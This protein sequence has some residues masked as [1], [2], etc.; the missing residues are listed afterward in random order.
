MPG[1]CG[2]GTE[3]ST[4]VGANSAAPRIHAVGEG[5]PPRECAQVRGHGP[6]R[7]QG[8]ARHRAR[9]RI[10][11]AALL[12]DYWDV[13]AALQS[14]SGPVA[15]RRSSPRSHAPCMPRWPNL[16]IAGAPKCG[17]TALARYLGSHPDVF[18]STPKEPFH[19][20]SDLQPN[21]RY[22]DEAAYVELFA[23]TA[24]RVRGEAST[25][26][27]YSQVAAP[28]IRSFNP[29]A[30]IVVMLR[31]PVEMLP[32]LHAQF[33]WSGLE[34][35]PDFGRAWRMQAERAPHGFLQYRG[36]A[37]FGEQLDRLYSVF[38]REQVLVVFMQDFRADT[39]SVYRH[40]LD[41]LGLDDDGRETFEVFNARKAPRSRLLHRLVR[42][43]PAPL[44]WMA[45]GVKKAL[46]LRRLGILARVER[47]NI[48]RVETKPLPTELRSEIQSA[49]APDIRRLEELT[50]RDLAAWLP[51]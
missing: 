13:T 46:G 38:P 16:F 51:S 7:Q 4:V 10:A 32:S 39:L 8:R 22:H 48:R 23:Q 40:T 20:S 19:F 50:G 36:V 33:R 26:Y 12:L 9:R 15:I 21:A 43:T 5:L 37:S 45:R 25:W 17:T 41:F 1:R 31:N 11:G 14:T 28:R 6:Q 30:R 24:A 27:L 34:H 18:M 3:G 47:M 29:D 44:A 35:E 42:H 2:A 49:L